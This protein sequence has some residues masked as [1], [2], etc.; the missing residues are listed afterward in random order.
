M[1]NFTSLT[2]QRPDPVI[3]EAT[4]EIPLSRG[5]WAII[6]LSDLELV[7][8]YRWSASG[9]GYAAAWDGTEV[10]LMHHI[11]LPRKNGFHTD[12]IN[13]NRQDN[14]RCNLRYATR[15]QNS[16]NHARRSDN[17]VGVTGICWDSS[18][19][20]WMATITLDGNTRRLGR[21]DSKTQAI[22]VRRKAEKKLFG[23]F[24][25]EA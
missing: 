22:N 16:A 8:G 7:K 18:R 15:S 1:R 9:G 13:G 24:Q 2:R 19:K 14:R 6:E 23:I 21:F 5:M 11:F 10:I 4:A 25:R 17:K 3:R 20:K 12:H